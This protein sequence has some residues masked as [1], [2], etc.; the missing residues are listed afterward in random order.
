MLTCV[1]RNVLYHSPVLFTSKQRM[2][3]TKLTLRIL[4]LQKSI[5]I[6]VYWNMNYLKFKRG[7]SYT[8][9]HRE[10]WWT[11]NIFMN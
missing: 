4:F 9:C 6:H 3:H 2:T 11:H 8:N 7:L 1:Q 5:N 10:L